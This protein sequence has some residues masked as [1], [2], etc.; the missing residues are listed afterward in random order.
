METGM[1][2]MKNL[3]K[4]TKQ[5]SHFWDIDKPCRHSPATAK[6]NA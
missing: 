1:S 4:K 5:Y 6:H 3:K 2:M